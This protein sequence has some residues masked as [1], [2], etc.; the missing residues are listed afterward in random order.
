MKA[1][2]FDNLTR[3]EVIM[4]V[5]ELAD[6]FNPDDKKR[7][8]VKVFR[9]KKTQ[10]AYQVDFRNKEYRESRHVIEPYSDWKK[11]GG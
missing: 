8:K 7:V 3:F 6:R 5:L 2:D 10:R 1:T 11:L 9:D 4:E